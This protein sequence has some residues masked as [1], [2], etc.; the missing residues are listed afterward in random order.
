[1]DNC[2]LYSL[3][4]S[5]FPENRNEVFLAHSR[6]NISFADI[7]HFS[8]KLGAILQT[9]DVFKGDR[10]MVQI[11]KSPENVMLYLACLRIGAVF[12]PLNTAYT[13]SEVAYFLEDADPK[14]FIC[15]PA[16]EATIGEICKSNTS[17][18]I[19]TLGN[20]GNGTL[21]D[22]MSSEQ[23]G[24]TVVWCDSDDLASII[25][26]SGTTGRS[27]GAMITHGN[28]TS[29]ALAL[30]KYWEWEP[31]DVLIHALP[32]FHIH[33]LFVAL[34]CA[35]LNASKVLF[36]ERFEVNKIIQ[37]LPAASVFMGVP[38][39]YTRLLA[40]PNFNKGVCRSIRLFISGSAP[41]LFETFSEFKER[42]NHSILERYGMTEAG[43]ITSNPYKLSQRIPNTVGYT[44]PGISARISD[45]KGKKLSPGEIGVL[46]IS[47]PNVFTGYW[48]MQEKTAEEFR[49]D[50]Y[51]ITGD[52][53]TM[54]RDGRISI[55]GR[56]KDL[57]ISG[58]YNVY[59]KEI[60][61]IIDKL[62][63]VKESTVIGVPHPDFGEAVVA[64]VVEDDGENISEAS[65]KSQLVNTLAKFKHPKKIFYT[66]ALPRNTM[67]K[68]QKNLLREIYAETFK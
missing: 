40:S 43:M 49:E 11:E 62:F 26:T 30:H 34:H 66:K 18:T 7:E 24:S 8:A 48:Q 38:T 67:G 1:M 54:E 9:L 21:I 59:P 50:G 45:T 6:I 12:V 46:E 63:G 58:G 55:V 60:E 33:G 37:D 15:D 35:L 10:V 31:G 16:N 5:R 64:V 2:N 41:L 13:A 14:M 65:I 52:M 27:K 28:L 56:L 20:K 42:T 19:L 25:Y 3:F 44:L 47:G 53:A 36:H 4:Q 22:K 17:T 57:V 39:F 32:I 51:F 23:Q 68:V 29:N 61:L